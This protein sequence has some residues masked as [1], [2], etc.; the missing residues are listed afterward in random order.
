[1]NDTP[2]QVSHGVAPEGVV[3]RWWD[4]L[5]GDLHRRWAAVRREPDA[6]YSTETVVVTGLLVV[7]A[8]IVIAIII[9]KVTEAANGI[10]LVGG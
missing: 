7:A 1:M 9:A 2:D 4:A 5:L 10:S 3:T 8:L 6:G